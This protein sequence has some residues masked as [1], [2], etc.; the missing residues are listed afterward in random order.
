VAPEYLPKLARL[1]W[2]DSSSVE[3]FPAL[4][5]SIADFKLPKVLTVGADL[6]S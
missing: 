3:E 4:E 2:A 6:L 1:E 5:V